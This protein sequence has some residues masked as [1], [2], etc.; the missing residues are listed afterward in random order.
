MNIEPIDIRKLLTELWL[1]GLSD[2]KIARAIGTTGATINRLRLGQ[3]RSTNIDR[4][5]KIANFHERYFRSRKGSRVTSLPCCKA[6]EARRPDQRQKRSRM[7]G[8][9]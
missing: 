4:A 2:E 1:S 5:T 7:V 8:T 6:A 3:H 9:S